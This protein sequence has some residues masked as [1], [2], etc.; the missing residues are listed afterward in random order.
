[1]GELGYSVHTGKPAYELVHGRPVWEHLADHPDETE[2]F[3]AA[4]ASAEVDGKALV[5]ACGLSRVSACSNGVHHEPTAQPCLTNVK[6]GVGRRAISIRLD[7]DAQH[8][9]RAL[10][11][12]GRSQSE[13]VREALIALARSRRRADLADEAERLSADR[14]DRAEKK[15]VAKMMESLCAAG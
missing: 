11:K 7:D 13:A 15:S 1:M 3:N 6:R 2:Q 8:A 10:T 14:G 12:A 5:K 9:L 4:M